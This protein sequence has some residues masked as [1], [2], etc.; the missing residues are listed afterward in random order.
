MDKDR[1]AELIA[2]IEDFSFECASL[3]GKLA[4]TEER[5]LEARG[6]FERAR[7]EVRRLRELLFPAR[8]EPR[9]EVPF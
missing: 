7:E 5:R 4:A 1:E 3:R 9:D 8:T 2:Q 6:D